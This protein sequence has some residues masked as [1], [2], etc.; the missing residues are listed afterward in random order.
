M[1]IWFEKNRTY[2]SPYL[3]FFWS[4]IWPPSDWREL[5]KKGKP[6]ACDSAVL[7]L[8]YDSGSELTR[9]MDSL[10]LGRAIC[11]GKGWNVK[12]MGFVH[13]HF[14]YTAMTYTTKTF[15]KGSIQCLTVWVRVFLATAVAWDGA[16]G[17][18]KQPTSISKMSHITSLQKRYSLFFS[19]RW[20]SLKTRL[21]H[22]TNSLSNIFFC[23]FQRT[24]TCS[25]VEHTNAG[26]TTSLT[27]QVNS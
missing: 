6:L 10:I 13:A 25:S 7:G 3:T 26:C 2:H 9:K 27:N 18:T 1:C 21:I 15:L 11:T 16:S 5:W 24:R 20:K 19:S 4:T 22:D 12:Q 17:V 8:G 23:N 14:R